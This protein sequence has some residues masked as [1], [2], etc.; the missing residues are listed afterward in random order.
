MMQYH[1]VI[2]GPG[3]ELSGSVAGLAELNGLSADLG[4]SADVRLVWQPRSPDPELEIHDRSTQ[5]TWAVEF[6]SFRD[7][8]RSTD[9]P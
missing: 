6:R 1:V 9:R 8:A 4:H 2:L 3:I 7:K 5:P